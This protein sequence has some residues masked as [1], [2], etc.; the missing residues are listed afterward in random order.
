[1]AILQITELLQ[2]DKP[3]TWLFYGDS[4]T[5]GALHTSGCRDYGELFGERIRWELGRS[6]DVVINTAISGNTTRELIE[7][8]EWRVARFLPNIAF[9]MIGV[10]DCHPEYLIS[11]EQFYNN[12]ET[13][14]SMFH[15][16]N[17]LL[18]LQTSNPMLPGATSE[19]ERYF[20]DYMDAVRKIAA[21]GN[22]PLID[23]AKHWQQNVERHYYWMSDGVHPNEYGH[24]VFAHLLLNELGLFD[25]QSRTCRLFIP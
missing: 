24:R 8:F 12:L 7:T 21:A 3:I 11:Y 2:V 14:V 16:I 1:M 9:L 15:K 17:T 20:P 5:Q 22:I 6:M 10:N 4:I 19:R 25:P 23:H 13:L 18:V